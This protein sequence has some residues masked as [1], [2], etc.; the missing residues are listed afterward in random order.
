MSEMEA[1]FY[2]AGRPLPRL[3]LE[4]STGP[5]AF[6]K[7]QEPGAPVVDNHALKEVW[8]DNMAL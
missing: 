2:Y 5:E 3:Q 4:A 7:G 8:E 6:R 1:K